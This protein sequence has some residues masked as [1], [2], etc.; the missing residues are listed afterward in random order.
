MQGTGTEASPYLIYTTQDLVD[1]Y[2]YNGIGIH[3]KLMNDLTI[4]YRDPNFPISSFSGVL[5]G[6]GKKVTGLDIY[7]PS[8]DYVGLFGYIS[9]AT[10]KNL[11]V[12]A[13]NVLGKSRI[14]LFAGESYENCIF[15]NVWVGNYSFVTTY[16]QFSSAYHTV[17]GFIGYAYNPVT[18]INCHNKD[19][20]LKAHNTLGGFIGNGAS[21]SVYDQCYSYPLNGNAYVTQGYV[22]AWSNPNVQ[23]DASTSYYHS[24]QGLM[25][26]Y[27]GSVGITD[28]QFKEKTAMQKFDW[29]NRWGIN[30]DFN[31]GYPMPKRFLPQ[32]I[33]AIVEQRSA[34]FLVNELSMIADIFKITPLIK[35]LEVM[36][37]IN[38]LS[39]S[40]YAELIR[41]VRKQIELIFQVDAINVKGKRLQLK[42][43]I[44]NI[45]NYVNEL[46]VSAVSTSNIQPAILN[47]LTR[48]LE[49]GNHTGFIEHLIKDVYINESKHLI[50][51]LQPQTEVTALAY[52]GDTVTL[53]V[54]F[55]TYDGM[56]IEPTDVKVKIYKQN[57]TS[58]ELISIVSLSE[59]E[60]QGIGQY[61]YRYTV[62][63]ITDTNYLIAEFSGLYNGQ[64][65]L[66]REKIHIR[67]V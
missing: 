2:S 13:C 20:I 35:Q 37:S 14:G 22:G 62:P 50:T 31:S 11:I 12:N 45:L 47:N 27:N 54:A 64:P 25:D 51:N 49:S 21:G 44:D 53:R 43:S 67:F 1:T 9:N 24:E 48:L 16:T 5:D 29:V 55:K 26:W 6:N 23:G 30:T 8:S 38:P 19:I 36:Y 59:T 66:A 61:E 7:K 33:P 15:E 60:K 18:F 3:F 34:L 42:K 39:I 10:I 56:D 58:N 17:G 41:V 52:T 57:P 46:T 40:A 65:T 4:P 32:D 28:T 63:D